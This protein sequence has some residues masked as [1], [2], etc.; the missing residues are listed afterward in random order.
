[1]DT[2]SCLVDDGANISDRFFSM[3][4]ITEEI[5]EYSLPDGIGEIEVLG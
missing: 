1:V 2:I 5:V 4:L 3:D